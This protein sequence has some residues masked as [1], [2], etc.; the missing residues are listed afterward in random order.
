MNSQ[1]WAIAILWLYAAFGAFWAVQWWLG[2]HMQ[3]LGQLIFRRPGA[4]SKLYFYLVSPGVVIHELSHWSF[5]KLLLV[6][7]GKL[8]LFKPAKGKGGPGMVTLGS[9]QIYCKDPF[10]WSL[11]GI[12]PLVVGVVFL[13][14]LG[15]LLGFNRQLATDKVVMGN[16]WQILT[17]IPGQILNSLS[18][19]INIVWLYLVFVISHSMVPSKADRQGWLLGL[20]LPVVLFVILAFSGNF[21]LP[22][23]WETG[24]VGL[25]GALIWVFGFAAVF[26]L[27][28]AL[29]VGLLELIMSGISPRR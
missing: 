7:T 20:I 27:L 24:L 21:K 10:R 2:R 1:T 11:I 9:V 15:A 14:L 23:S 22:T 8:N 13:L 6:R 26:N 25:L 4:G 28:V 29:V 3:R 5:A 17:S 19:P 16:T 12:A 18:Q